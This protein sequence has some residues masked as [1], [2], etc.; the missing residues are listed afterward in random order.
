MLKD[1]KRA[2]YKSFETIRLVST[3]KNPTVRPCG[4]RNDG[5]I[6]KVKDSCLLGRIRQLAMVKNTRPKLAICITMYNEDE[7]LLQWTLRGI[8]QNYNAMY[9][10]D[11]LHMRQS[12]MVVVVV[13][14]G[15]DKICQS[16]KDWAHKH[17]LLDER[18]LEERGF[19]YRKENEDA[20]DGEPEWDWKMRDIKEVMAKKVKKRDLPKN[21]LHMF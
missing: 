4:F 12:D 2:K 5:S 15:Y 18:I 3:K 14:D 7:G 10:N 20:A 8:I 13:C 11:E 6:R 21:L 19:M 16:F 17:E 1:W 9:S